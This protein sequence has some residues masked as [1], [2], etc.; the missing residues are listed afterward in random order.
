MARKSPPA[1][2]A[3][4]ADG[5]S[6][7]P[8]PAPCQPRRDRD[9]RL[10]GAWR[11][12]G[13]TFR[14]GRNRLEP[15]TA[16]RVCKQLGELGFINSSLQFAAAF[17]LGFIPFLMVLSVV[18]GSGL[19]RAIVIRSGFSARAGQDLATLFAHG[20]TAP[21]TLSLI[22]LVL[23]FLGGAAISHMVQDWYAKI[24]R[25]EI[26]GWKAMVHRVEWL[27]GVFGF[28]A[29]Q[30]VIGRRIGPLRGP[31][32]AAGAQFLLAVAFWWWS[33]HC[34][35]CRQIPWRRLFPGGLATAVCYTGLGVYITYVASSSIVSNEAMYGPFGAVM[36]LLTAEIG[37]GVALQL[38]AV[39]GATA[40]RGSDPDDHRPGRSRTSANQG[41]TSWPQQ[42]SPPAHRRRQPRLPA[43]DNGCPITLR[44]AVSSCTTRL[45]LSRL[46]HGSDRKTQATLRNASPR[47]P[48]PGYAPARPLPPGQPD[49][50]CACRRPA[51]PPG[52]G[53]GVIPGRP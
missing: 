11:K 2:P 27:A 22:G 28:V 8:A 21:T 7:R 13:E 53:T 9:P 30:A 23:A 38:G 37:L 10:A 50:G 3:T 34:L 26:H 43:D 1:G 42:P 52:R 41:R 35:L 18:L 46:R 14:A 36:T 51:D 24:F 44:Q 31:V 17:T 39:I 25:V 48:D 4:A 16:G 12:A 40:G 49:P 19:S 15:T 33:L 5:N 47:Q 29:L 45:A 6:S 20:R 32:A